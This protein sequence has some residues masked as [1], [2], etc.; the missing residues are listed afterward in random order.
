MSINITNDHYTRLHISYN[1]A[2]I[3]P[4]GEDTVGEDKGSLISYD[5]KDTI[6]IIIAKKNISNYYVL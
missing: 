6:I 4:L 2:Y 5:C 1:Y 3:P